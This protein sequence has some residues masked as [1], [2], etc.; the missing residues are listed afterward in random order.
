MAAHTMLVS[1]GFGYFT[2][3]VRKPRGFHAERGNT[4]L[5]DGVA[6]RRSL[7]T[8]LGAKPSLKH[9]KRRRVAA[10]EDRF[11]GEL[12]VATRHD[13]AMIPRRRAGVA[14]HAK[15]RMVAEAAGG[16]IQHKT[17]PHCS[18]CRVTGE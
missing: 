15:C 10:L 6:R 9:G 2:Q 11:R 16:R 1:G 8:I 14:Y 12:A 3:R 18:I 7:D 4:L 13:L 5:D 17:D